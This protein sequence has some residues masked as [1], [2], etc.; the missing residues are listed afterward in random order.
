M[1][2]TTEMEKAVKTLEKSIKDVIARARQDGITGMSLGC[3]KQ[4][5]PT[6]GLTCSVPV[7]H[8]AFRVAAS[9]VAKSFVTVADR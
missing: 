3:L 2:A 6:T 4:N 9:N 7:Y 8:E 5:T 1:N